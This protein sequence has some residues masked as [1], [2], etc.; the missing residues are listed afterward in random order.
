MKKTMCQMTKTLHQYLT[1]ISDESE[2][3]PWNARDA[4]SLAKM[5]AKAL[6]L[7]DDLHCFFMQPEYAL[8]GI[9]KNGDSLYG[10]D[11]SH[12][13]GEAARIEELFVECQAIVASEPSQPEQI[14]QTSDERFDDLCAKIEA[15]R[16]ELRDTMNELA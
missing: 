13:E 1:K 2:K 15:L 5:A 8:L 3:K 9:S 6:D 10:V 7:L 16:E 12:L 14:V 4:D 11:V